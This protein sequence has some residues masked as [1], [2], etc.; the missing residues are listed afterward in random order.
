Y[1]NMEDNKKTLDDII[2]EAFD[3]ASKDFEEKSAGVKDFKEPE[4]GGQVTQQSKK[5][6]AQDANADVT[7]KVNT[8]VSVE[9]DDVSD[10][11]VKKEP[12]KKDTDEEDT[13]KEDSTKKSTKDKEPDV[14]KTAEVGVAKSLQ[15]AIDIDKLVKSIDALKETISKSNY[16]STLALAAGINKSIHDTFSELIEKS[17]ITEKNKTNLEESTKS[18]DEDKDD[19]EEKAVITEKNKT[20]LEESTKSADKDKKDKDDDDDEDADTDKAVI[21]EKNKTNLEESTKSTSMAKDPDMQEKDK[22]KTDIEVSEK[23]AEPMD[24]D[25]DKD[26]DKAACMDKDAKKSATSKDED[27]ESV[28]KSAVEQPKAKAVQYDTDSEDVNK[29]AVANND[30]TDIFKGI[31]ENNVDSYCNSLLEN[32]NEVKKS[33]N[34]QEGFFGLEDSRKMDDLYIAVKSAKNSRNVK[35]YKQSYNNL[36]SFVNSKN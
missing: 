15:P 18:A 6:T 14:A 12:D 4:N 28:A 1:K 36:V 5:P 32:I 10:S 22:N 26:K 29:S 30:D 7:P 16:T 8:N 3:K 21:T 25:K 11:A 2:K 9:G 20:N 33:I 13:D 31:N 27:V 35:A 19:E 34:K 17:V 24:K 23:S